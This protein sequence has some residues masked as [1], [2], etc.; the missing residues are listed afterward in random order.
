[1]ATRSHIA[2]KDKKTNK[3]HMVYC[4]YDG[5]LDYNGNMLMK[6]YN[7][8]D[9]V[10]KLISK[11]DFSSLYE[12]IERISYYGKSK[13]TKPFIYDKEQHM[14]REE[15]NYLFK[16]NKWYYCRWDD[17]VFKPLQKEKVS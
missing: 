11:G 4:H 3:I 9:K 13:D 2:Y 12:D 7:N 17:K 15:Y 5:Y 8:Y 16:N 6:Y 14:N 10:V 1:M